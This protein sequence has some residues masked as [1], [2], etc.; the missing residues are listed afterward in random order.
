QPEAN[1]LIAAAA[2]EQ[3]D[4]PT[5]RKMESHFVA[6]GAWRELAEF[7]RERIRLAQKT[8]EK[9]EH[10]SRLAEVLEDALQDLHGAATGY[11]DRAA[12]RRRSDPR[13]ARRVG[14]DAPAC[15]RAGRAVPAAGAARGEAHRRRGGR[16][17]RLVGGPRGCVDRSRGAGAPG[18]DR[19]AHR[20]CGRVG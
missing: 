1:A 4:A 9:A 15:A 20:G 17:R 13:S 11:R 7:Y 10:L 12:G 19:A 5:L 2:T 18:V 16:A 8:E 6:R 14:A 3:L